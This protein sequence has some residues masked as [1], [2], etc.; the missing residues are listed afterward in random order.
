MN[1]TQTQYLTESIDNNLDCFDLVTINEKFPIYDDLIKLLSN[2]FQINKI[3]I[4]GGAIRDA[5]LQR[6]P[7]DIDVY[8][9]VEDFCNEYREHLLNKLVS[10]NA[11]IIDMSFKN[12]SFYSNIDCVLNNQHIQI[13]VN[14]LEPQDLIREFDY[15]IC[16]YGYTNSALYS[17]TNAKLLIEYL[18]V[19]ETSPYDFM[20]YNKWPEL[21]LCNIN[22]DMNTIK[23]GHVFSY[24]YKVQFSKELFTY[25]ADLILK[26]Y[27][28]FDFA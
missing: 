12:T 7:K 25:L 19:M 17:T 8:I 23:R 5:L 4:A 6:Q 16:Q 1:L 3:T 21:K 20:D 15:N 14:Q 2:T 10:I 24:K 18:Q 13:M 26:N 11:D 28:E 22:N 27:S 9:N